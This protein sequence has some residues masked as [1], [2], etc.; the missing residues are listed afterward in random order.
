MKL[1]EKLIR[2]LFILLPCEVRIR[3]RVNSLFPET[4][5]VILRRPILGVS[6]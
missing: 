6:L 1:F 4:E 5:Y 2:H 3:V